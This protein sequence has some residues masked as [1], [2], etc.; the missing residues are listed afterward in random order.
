MTAYVPMQCQ[1]CG[2]IVPDDLRS[3]KTDEEVG[4]SEEEPTAEE[5][6]LVRAGWFR[7]PRQAKVLVLKCP[8]C[9]ATSRWFRSRD[10]TV[11]LN[12]NRWGRLC[13]EQE[14]LK[15]DLAAYLGIQVRTCIPVDWDHVW[16]EYLPAGEETAEWAVCDENARNFAVRLDE[17]IG[18]WT[19]VLAIHPDPALC[20][21]VTDRYL[22]CKSQGGLADDHFA[23]EMDKYRE[24]VSMAR[25]DAS[26]ES[27]QARSVI[28]YAF[29]RAGF[30]KATIEREMRRAVKDYKS[31]SSCWHEIE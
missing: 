8:D 9:G 16:N 31:G 21:D 15:L 27:T 26:G 24:K 2:H 7:G 1:S 12:P 17:G 4:I 13:G 29:E 30:D 10:P 19:G 3:G 5:A 11:I 18:S 28:G 22:S 14:D 20:G 6:P 23:P 25:K